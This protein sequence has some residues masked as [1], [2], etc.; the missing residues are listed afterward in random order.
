MAGAP[1][2]NGNMNGVPRVGFAP[3]YGIVKFWLYEQQTI[4][5]NHTFILKE[6]T[7]NIFVALQRWC[8]LLKR[9]FF[10]AYTSRSK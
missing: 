5:S 6:K 3:M 9:S 10:S 2:V 7:A 8:L 1:P 4:P